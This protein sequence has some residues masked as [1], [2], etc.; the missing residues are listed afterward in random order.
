MAATGFAIFV[1]ATIRWVYDS[2]ARRKAC[3]WLSNMTI[4]LTKFNLIS[5][6]QKKKESKQTDF[7]LKIELRNFE[8][9]ID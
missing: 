3:S 6:D 5:C 7:S 8:K 2:M 4:V 1:I 9:Y